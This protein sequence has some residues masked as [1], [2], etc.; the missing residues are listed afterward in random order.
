[1]A[2]T[3]LAEEAERRERLALSRLAQTLVGALEL[4]RYEF[5]R[6]ACARGTT[7]LL[8]RRKPLS[9]PHAVAEAPAPTPAPVAVPLSTPAEAG[10]LAS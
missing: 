6:Q 10:R 8:R 5:V 4:D 3:R 2:A 1:V 9:D 7:S